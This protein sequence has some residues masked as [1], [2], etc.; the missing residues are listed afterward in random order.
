MSDEFAVYVLYSESADRLYIGFSASSIER[1]QWHNWKSSKGFTL[2]HRPWKMV[3]I[4]VFETK[5][6]A[7]LREQM[8]KGGQ[9]RAWIRAEVLS[10]MKAIGFTSA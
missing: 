9:G 7:M 1:F 3:H 6:Q 8:L 2:A 5:A 4:E 10:L